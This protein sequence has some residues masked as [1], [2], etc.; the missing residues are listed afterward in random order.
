MR[1]RGKYGLSFVYRILYYYFLSLL[2]FYERRENIRR[3][4]K[5]MYRE[6]DAIYVMSCDVSPQYNIILRHM[7]MAL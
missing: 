4:M 5:K 2:C 1:I 6:T 3:K 7:C